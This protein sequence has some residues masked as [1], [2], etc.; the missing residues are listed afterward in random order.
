MSPLEY[1]PLM[2]AYYRKLGF[3][4]YPIYEPRGEPWTA[5]RKPLAESTVVLVCSAGLSRK[6]Q[7]PYDPKGKD[8]LSIREIPADTRP[9]DLV[10]NYSYFDHR[11]AD[12]D[13][14]CVFPLERLRELEKEGFIGRMA[15]VEYA[16]GVGR[17]R[18]PSTPERL[19]A[20]VAD[21]LRDRFGS[22]GVDAVLL[23]PT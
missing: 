12:G 21:D 3:D 19:Q 14:N 2:Q 5:L 10:I 22:H 15:P 17:W 8:D 20:E 18:D 1:I 7:K 23:I 9:E 16:M 4:D 13:I 11:D 6:D